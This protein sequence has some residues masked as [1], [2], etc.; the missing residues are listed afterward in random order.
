MPSVCFYFQVHQPIRLKQY[1]VFQMGI[2]HQY[3]DEKVNG[4]IMRKVANKCYIPANKLMLDLIQMHE[5]RFK[6][7][8]SITGT[9]IEQM[10][11]YSPEALDTF[12]ALSKTGCVEFLSETYYHSL[13]SLYSPEEFKK[14]VTQHSDLM[15][16]LFN[17]R[18]KVFRNTEL[19][20][21]DEIG[22][23]IEGM[24]Y[25]GMI[26]E[27]ADDIL[28]WRSPHFV[29]RRPSGNLGLLLKS[30]RLSDDVAF[31]F[32]SRAWN[33]WP[34]TAPKFASWVHRLSGNG[35]LVNL[36]MDYET[37]GEHQW[38]STGIFDFMKALPGEVMKNQ[39]WNF[40]TP[41]EALNR[42]SP[43]AELSYPRLVSWADE[44]RSITAWRGNNMQTSALQQ[45]FELQREVYLKNNPSTLDLWRKLQ[46][47]DHF[48]YMCT[49]W[50]ADGD[51]HAYFNHYKSPYE[52]FINFMNVLNDFRESVLG[53]RPSSASSLPPI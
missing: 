43:T 3:F 30:Y 12:V 16:Q 21:S 51:V 9:A 11:K 6:I 50:F 25:Q 27:G 49:K 24:G 38:E 37:F 32:S 17:Q 10:V 1:S 23:L 2:D 44:D 14:Q 34:L 20:Y 18:P 31:R 7:S 45:L 29:Y 46:T 40:V 52:A 19:I 33:E 35:Q 15:F 48:Y 4:D 53:E 41:S 13:A 26:A 22:A 5:G 47:S 8:Y 39:E 36:F 42:Y 28:G